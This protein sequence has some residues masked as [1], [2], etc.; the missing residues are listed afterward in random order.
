MELRDRLCA[1]LLTRTYTSKKIDKLHPDANW[2]NWDKSTRA[3]GYAVID[4]L[5]KI[6]FDDDP[7]GY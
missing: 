4:E 1:H 3:W 7:Y 5:E 6:K 2:P